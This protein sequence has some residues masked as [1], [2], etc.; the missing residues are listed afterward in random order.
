MLESYIKMPEAGLAE[1][2]WNAF[3]EDAT[4][5]RVEIVT[6]ELGG[7]DEI[8]II[9]NG[10]GITL[11]RATNAFAT[12]GD[13]W[14]RMPGTL[15]KS[16]RP[17]HGRHGRGR[18][19]AFAL[20]ASVRWD[21][22]AQ[23]VDGGLSQVVAQGRRS[24]LQSMEVDAGINPADHSGTRVT[25]QNIETAAQKAFDSVKDLTSGLLMEF[26]LHLER[27]GDFKV[28]VCGETLDPRAVIESK[29]DIPLELPTGVD[30]AAV[31]TVIE[32]K[33]QDVQRRL[34]LCRQD[35]S[36]VDELQPGVQAPGAEFTA[37]LR[38]DG[39][40]A[41]N[42][43]VME[44]DA[45][46]PVG[47]V[48]TVARQ[49]LRDHLSVNSRRREAEAVKRWSAEGVYPYK[50]EAKTAVES[51][52][53]DVF[54]MV[55]MAASRTLEE[56]KSRGVKSLSL[57]LLKET[58]ESDPESLLPILQKVV[59]LPSARIA[60]FREILE[61]TSLTQLIQAG[62][63]VGGRIEFLNGLDKILFDKQIKTRLL[64]RRQL[65]RMLAHETWVFGE[66]WALTGDDE[67][68][69]AVLQ[70]FIDKLGDAELL[71]ELSSRTMSEP[72]YRED[73]SIAIPDLVLG[74]ALETKEA[75]SS[76][77]VVELKR[78]KHKLTDDDVTQLRS[79]ASAIVNDERFA[80]PNVKWD[81]WLVGNETTR[82]VDE[83][84]NQ[85]NLPF[86]V[87]F[88]GKTYSLTVKT[89]SEVIGEARHRLQFVQDS[90]QYE[91]TRDSGL[92]FLRSKYAEYLPEV[93]F[94]DD[95]ADDRSSE[96]YE[97]APHVAKDAPGDDYA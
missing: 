59:K 23:P 63:E 58:L 70:K 78:P 36:I 55:A 11:E 92:A 6:N 46:S 54:N 64:E 60:E 44:G 2:I 7:I 82:T 86:G 41:G 48:L 14:K 30:G 12:V 89:W 28:I 71:A 87:V 93:A 42:P 9:D 69:G 27:F 68:L 16:K 5:V 73:G 91:S 74:R 53:R 4:S 39:F 38:W 50:K 75:H 24:D 37:Y 10:N 26:A 35:G 62:H 22:T 81:F 76:H 21:S 56:T 65:H 79:Y 52:T 43:L 3:D 90:L 32:W 18:Y 51:A 84:R 19:A 13:S 57:S 96:A 61:R 80:R 94:V 17:V 40:D 20:G 77:L 85:T 97:G 15:S 8:A 33:L 95:D 34:Y 66:E 29:N 47:Q 83:A 49:A 67:P 72:I 1:L 88:S 31:L 25:V 45:E